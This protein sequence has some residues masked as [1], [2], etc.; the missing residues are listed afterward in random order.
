MK[1]K[2]ILKDKNLKG[3]EI[4]EKIN[5]LSEY[6]DKMREYNKLT[7]R[8]SSYIETADGVKAQVITNMPIGGGVSD[9]TSKMISKQQELATILQERFDELWDSLIEIENIIQSV[10]VSLF[11]TILSLRY[12][13]G[14][15][16]ENVAV[17]LNYSWKQIH[18]LHIEALEKTE[19]PKKMTLNDTL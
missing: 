16:W 10:E 2:E 13:D 17:E 11:R 3:I 5:Y 12:I 18:R 6:K 19:I 7:E 14:K 15:R 1:T 8:Y 4:R 9:R